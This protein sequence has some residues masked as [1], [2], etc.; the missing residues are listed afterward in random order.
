MEAHK[1]RAGHRGGSEQ[2]LTCTGHRPPAT[3]VG[4]DNKA[5][6][7]NLHPLREEADTPYHELLRYP[8]LASARLEPFRIF[9]G[10]PTDLRRS[11]MVAALATAYRC[12]RSS[13]A[14]PQR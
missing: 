7:E 5:C 1:L 13:T 11:A 9:R 14:A 10:D 8:T 2:H 6:P 4:C 12:L 3:C